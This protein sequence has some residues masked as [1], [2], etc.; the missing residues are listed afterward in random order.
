VPLSLALALLILTA[1]ARGGSEL[2]GWYAL[3]S[4]MQLSGEKGTGPQGQTVFALLYTITPG[5]DRAIERQMPIP[6]L[7]GRPSLRLWAKATR[8]L[9]LAFVLVDDQGQEHECARTLVPGDWRELNFDDF[10]PPVG[11][12]VQIVT[13]RLVDR[14]GGLG[15]QGPVSLKL[16][17]LPQ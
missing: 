11:G 16:V 7:Q 17:G 10:R 13:V 8:V 14:T 2:Y 9:H 12:W 5:Q 6:G 15:G 4:G 1:C 3:Q